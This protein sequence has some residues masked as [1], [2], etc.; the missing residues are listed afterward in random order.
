M[1]YNTDILTSIGACDAK[2]AKANDKKATL[3]LRVINLTA[4][5]TN[6]TRIDTARQQEMQELISLL[7]TKESE[8][9]GLPE[10]L[11]K[12]VAIGKKMV[13]ESKI[14]HLTLAIEAETD[15]DALDD[16]RNLGEAQARIAAMNEFITAVEAKKALLA[17]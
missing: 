4:Q 8:I 5:A 6:S 7:A 12:R 3:E 14:Y 1:I 11:T 2:L 16:Q 9:A 15:N 10:G 13:L 17:A